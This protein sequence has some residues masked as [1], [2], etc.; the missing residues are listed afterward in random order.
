MRNED[1]GEF[2][3]N[4]KYFFPFSLH[5]RNHRI[6]ILFSICFDHREP[7]KIFFCLDSFKFILYNIGALD[8]SL[9]VVYSQCGTWLVLFNYI[10]WGKLLL[11]PVP[12]RMLL[13]SVEKTVSQLMPWYLRLL[14]MN[15][16]ASPVDGWKR[17]F[18][19]HGF[20]FIQFN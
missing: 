2:D 16:N 12:V 4:V 9:F 13:L 15:K 3:T 20:P 1:F 7:K 14:Q 6:N 11:L 5:K 19:L 8:K 17:T 18:A 10:E